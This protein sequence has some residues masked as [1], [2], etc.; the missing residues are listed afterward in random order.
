MWPVSFIESSFTSKV[1][2]EAWL[3]CTPAMAESPPGLFCNAAP[4]TIQVRPAAAMSEPA[5]TLHYFAMKGRAEV[6]RMLL[7]EAQVPYDLRVWFIG[8]SWKAFKADPATSPAFG[9]LP[10]LES[11]MLLPNGQRLVQSAAIALP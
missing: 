7:E 2:Y 11:D 9:M 10:M 8:P 3:R 5:L 1:Q 4:V 6:A